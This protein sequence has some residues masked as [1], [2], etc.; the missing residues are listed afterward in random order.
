MRCSS[1]FISMVRIFSFFSVSV[2]LLTSGCCS[3]EKFEQR[4][5]GYIGDSKV[6]LLQDFGQPIR[7]ER[8][9]GEELVSFLR[10]RTYFVNETGPSMHTTKRKTKDGYTID[11]YTNPGTPAH[12]VEQK[13]EMSFRIRNGRVVD[14]KSRGNDCCD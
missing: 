12:Y 8:V 11:T 2:I 10:D 3:R 14:W 4:L 13:C 6:R 5:N 9:G 1:Y 7:T